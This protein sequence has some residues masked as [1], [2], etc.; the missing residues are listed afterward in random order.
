MHL[1]G[2][3]SRHGLRNCEKQGAEMTGDGDEQSHQE[4]HLFPRL[5]SHHHNDRLKILGKQR[6]S[7][8]HHHESHKVS[9]CEQ[10]YHKSC[11]PES[12]GTEVIAGEDEQRH[13]EGQK[14]GVGMVGKSMHAGC[15]HKDGTRHGEC[16]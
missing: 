3:G 1:R 11:H 14:D 5:E 7:E 15:F 12:S 13:A 6:Q 16:R 9:E 2:R 8:C 4:K 10:V